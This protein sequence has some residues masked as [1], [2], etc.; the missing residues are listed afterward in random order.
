MKREGRKAVVGCS[1]SGQSWQIHC[2][3]NTWI[4]ND[5]DCNEGNVLTKQLWHQMYYHDNVAMLH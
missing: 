3:Q 2:D 5:K 1:G 4:G